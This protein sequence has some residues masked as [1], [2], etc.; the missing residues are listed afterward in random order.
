[1]TSRKLRPVTATSTSTSCEPGST[2]STCR[3]RDAQVHR[4][5]SFRPAWRRP[6]GS[7]ANA[8][9]P[10]ILCSEGHGRRRRDEEV[11][12][13]GLR[14]HDC[15]KAL[16]GRMRRVRKLDP[17]KVDPRKLVGEGSNKSEHRLRSGWSAA[18][19]ATMSL[20]FICASPPR[21]VAQDQAVRR[22]SRAL[23]P[24]PTPSEPKDCASLSILERDAAVAEPAGRAKPIDG[25]Q[26]HLGETAGVGV[27]PQA[28]PLAT[29]PPPSARPVGASATMSVPDPRRYLP[30]SSPVREASAQALG[31]PGIG[32]K[33]A[34]A[35]SAWTTD[36][37]S[38]AR[39]NE[40]AIVEA[41]SQAGLLRQRIS[42]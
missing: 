10:P 19:T 5:N 41:R 28:F 42:E 27:R 26:R 38:P 3:R 29:R 23:S 6:R 32:A 8:R 13:G 36:P 33:P 12:F 20:V 37:P 11:R 30:A 16:C 34:I 2:R 7:R 15:R 40:T 35:R 17:P 24:G 39:A 18:V 22:H 14:K 4:A 9:S 21:E 25:I 1:M 31:R